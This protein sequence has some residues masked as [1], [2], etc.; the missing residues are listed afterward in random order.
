MSIIL[1][2]GY[3][4]TALLSA[5][6][7]WYISSH[8]YLRGPW[9]ASMTL[10]LLAVCVTTAI[11][12]LRH[13]MEYPS[14]LAVAIVALLTE[15]MLI[16]SPVEAWPRLYVALIRVGFGLM[17]VAAWF[18]VLWHAG[19]PFSQRTPHG[20]AAIIGLAGAL[21]WL[22]AVLFLRPKG[23]PASGLW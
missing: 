21:I 3:V 19:H 16:V 17:A 2:S 11:Q 8:R 14:V 4:F 18:L 5:I 7:I 9:R 15:V 1:T 20:L 12:S 10:A 6:G 23:R 13:G 22:V